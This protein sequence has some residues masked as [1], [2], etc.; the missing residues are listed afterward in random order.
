VAISADGHWWFLLNVSPDIRR[1]VL[2]FPALGPAT[3]GVRGTAI[4]GAVLT[5][6]ELDHVSG[7]LQLR[8]GC[9]FDVYSTAIVHTWLTKCFPVE[10]ILAS[11]SPRPWHTVQLDAP[12]DLTL[13]DGAPS[14]LQCRAFATGCDGPRYASAPTAAG[15]VIGLVIRDLATTG[16]L[17]Y[18]PCTAMIDPH[19]RPMTEGI[20]CLLLDGTFWA[21]D[22]PRQ[23]GISQR[24]ARE[25]GHLPVGGETGSLSWMTGLAVRHRAYVHINNTNPMLDC[26]SDAFALVRENG[27]RVAVDG[28][29]FLL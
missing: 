29:E 8:E 4:A 28:D 13:P 17:A 10:P 9:A 27:I 25:M 2:D 14:G 16:R 5:D 22:E 21:D 12:F 23:W 15:A 3:G 6:A 20:D 11:F 26:R 24:S 19:W 1:Q 18:I 7:L